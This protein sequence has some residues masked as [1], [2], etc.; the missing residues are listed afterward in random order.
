MRLSDYE[1]HKLDEEYSAH[2]DSVE[3]ERLR[4]TALAPPITDFTSTD[5]LNQLDDVW[6]LLDRAK[7]LGYGIV[8]SPDAAQQLLSILENAALA[9][10]RGE[11]C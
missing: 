5:I 9:K 1:Q 2:M 3:G 8:L 10:T 7:R 11:P 4:K 6:R